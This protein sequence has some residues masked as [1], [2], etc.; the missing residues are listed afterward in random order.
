MKIVESVKLTPFPFQHD[1]PLTRWRDMSVAC[2]V[3]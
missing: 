3:S 2:A 1:E